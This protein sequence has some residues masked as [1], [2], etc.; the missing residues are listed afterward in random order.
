MK[1]HI[2]DVNTMFPQNK[3]HISSRQLSHRH[4]VRGEAS[5]IKTLENNEYM[6]VMYIAYR[7]I[8][9]FNSIRFMLWT[10]TDIHRNLTGG[11]HTHATPYIRLGGSNNKLGC[12]EC[13]LQTTIPEEFVQGDQGYDA[14]NKC[15]LQDTR[16]GN[17]YQQNWQLSVLDRFNMLVLIQNW[18][19]LQLGIH[20][21]NYEISHLKNKNTLQSV[22]VT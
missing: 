15:P 17:K 8:C 2:F 11:L 4:P 10:K 22:F 1:L 16:D 18:T 5:Q 14:V 7:C 13:K 21:K 19:C 3:I 20:S 9:I 12:A 6:Y